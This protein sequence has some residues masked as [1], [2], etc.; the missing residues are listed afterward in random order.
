MG[1]A[2]GYQE[3]FSFARYIGP[4]KYGAPLDRGTN[5]HP[6]HDSALSLTTICGRF[7][8]DT[9][10]QNNFFFFLFSLSF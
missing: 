2:P 3:E 4:T 9:Q 1:G 7:Y 5:N 6:W 10:A 8:H